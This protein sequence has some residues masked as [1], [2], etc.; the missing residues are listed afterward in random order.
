MKQLSS[1]VTVF[2]LLIVSSASIFI[3]AFGGAFAY[4]TVVQPEKKLQRHAQIAGVDVGGM[5]V[6]EVEEILAGTVTDW[7]QR[8][9]IEL[10]LFDNLILVDPNAVEFNISESISTAL[11]SGYAMLTPTVSAAIVEQDL[12]RLTYPNV[13]SWIDMDALIKAL[14]EEISS[15]NVMEVR[16][17]IHDYFTTEHQRTP[18]K[19]VETTISISDPNGYFERWVKALDGEVI[20]KRGDFSLVERLNE[21]GQPAVRSESLNT[22][23]SAIFQTIMGTNF[24]LIERHIGREVPGYVDIGLEAIVDPGLMDLKFYN[25]N[26]YDYTLNAK[27]ENNEL[28]VS[29]SGLP[30]LYSYELALGEE[31]EVEPRKIVQFSSKLGPKDTKILVTGKKG[32]FIEVLQIVRGLKNEE[33]EIVVVSEDYYPATHRVEQKGLQKS[34]TETGE[35]PDPSVDPN[36]P[37]LDSGQIEPG[38]E[39]PIDEIKGEETEDDDLEIEF[40]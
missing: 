3:F 24:T 37:E 1:Y 19:I 28:T 33:L 7:R 4:E 31:K 32:Y 9:I 17:D 5:S 35:N 22:L 36:D 29:I 2:M 34:G 16:L 8:A 15:T 6:S 30:F 27:Y 40:K 26:Y 12:E 21:L 13:A 20:E 38:T 14:E 10:V 23:S 18:E 11:D 25:K 39:E